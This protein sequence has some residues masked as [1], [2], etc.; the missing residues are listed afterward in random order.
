MDCS[1][2]SSDAPCVHGPPGCCRV[3]ARCEA[4]R[5]DGPRHQ[6]KGSLEDEAELHAPFQSTG[7]LPA[8]DA[9]AGSDN[10]LCP[11]AACSLQWA[12]G[13]GMVP[14]VVAG[15]CH[16]SAPYRYIPQKVQVQADL[17]GTHAR[18]VAVASKGEDRNAGGAGAAWTGLPVPN[19]TLPPPAATFQPR[20]VWVRAPGAQARRS[21]AAGNRTDVPDV[22]AGSRAH[23]AARPVAAAMTGV[24]ANALA[25]VQA[26]GASPQAAVPKLAALL[27]H[28]AWQTRHGAVRALEDL[29]LKA[30]AAVPALVAALEDKDESVRSAAARAL[31]AAGPAAAAALPELL[32][33][34][35]RGRWETR[36]AA[37]KAL[38][39][40][41]PLAAV[42]VP[43]L[44]G[45][46]GDAAGQVRAAAAG[47]LGCLGPG[48]PAAAPEL[49]AALGD[50]D[51]RV[52]MAAAQALGAL[53][54]RAGAARAA[55]R[56]AL[57]DV[58]V[59]VR[60][61]AAAA[62]VAQGPETGVAAE[63]P[64]PRVGRE[65]L[66]G[67]ERARL[68]RSVGEF[69]ASALQGWP[70]S[71]LDERSAECIAC[72]YRMDC[73]LE[74]F[75]ISRTPCGG[76]LLE[77]PVGAIQ[78]IYSYALH[79]EGPFPGKALSLLKP[80]QKE[81]LLMV[82]CEAEGLDARP[83]CA[84][85]RR[86]LGIR[87]RASAPEPWWGQSLLLVDTC[88][89]NLDRFLECMLVLAVSARVKTGAL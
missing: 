4:S 18:R 80:E 50:G 51:W 29:G 67:P 12:T 8:T 26:P 47:A 2:A 85:A 35:E 20:Q 56:A 84:T 72:E 36:E 48:A 40:L 70:C 57:R 86:C 69:A 78:R 77:M 82:V 32:A 58:E 16:G 46:L 73:Q 81:L 23:D 59:S 34:L 24:R 49:A 11:P 17:A 10:A 28:E 53:G 62:L 54:P 76:D 41:G 33:L 31:G 13:A 38:G 21:V 19:G 52:R 25:S 39:A 83:R 75:T 45:A 74:R 3:S 66:R 14:P 5:P 88:A 71:L 87:S 63:L 30:E 37:A 61:H 64:G 68:E 22:I 42:A 60:L 43:G 15:A 79:G 27:K 65:G 44:V 9:A 7:R 6:A 1:H 89:N 55:L